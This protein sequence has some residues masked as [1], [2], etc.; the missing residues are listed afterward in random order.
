M[1]IIYKAVTIFIVAVLVVFLA[2]QSFQVG[3][4]LGQL[5]AIRGKIKYHLV[6]REDSS[7]T[8]QEIEGEVK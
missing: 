2:I 6:T 5:D 1:N 8:W 4:R 3:Y 7:R